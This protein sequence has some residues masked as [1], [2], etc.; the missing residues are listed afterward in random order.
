MTAVWLD[1]DPGHDDAFA[2]ILSGHNSALHLLG[3]ST[4]AGNQSVEKTTTNAITVLAISGLEHV[5]VVKGQAVPLLRPSLVCPEIH[6]ETG[7]DC[8]KGIPELVL[9]LAIPK[10]AVLHMYDVI[11]A[12]PRKVTIVATACLTN[13]ALLLTIFPEVK[14]NIDKIVLLG[15]AIGVGNM[16]PAAEFNILVDPEAAKIVF[17]SG[18]PIVMVPLEVSHTALVTPDIIARIQALH[19]PYADLMVDLLLYFAKSYLELFKFNHPPLHDP[20]AV[21]YVI[22]PEIFQTTFMRVDIET[23]SELCFGQTVCDI[24]HMSKRPKNVTVATRVD[25]P[26]FWNLLLDALGKANQKSVLN[27]PKNLQVNA[28]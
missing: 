2:I 12:Y 26:V 9:K 19:T 3:V 24:Y 11:S 28:S 15:G 1:C 27:A 5:D 17:E 16:T 13:I 22:S 14:A 6:G 4:V 25:I 8:A 7:L 18:L 21:A 23:Q 10:K 20:L